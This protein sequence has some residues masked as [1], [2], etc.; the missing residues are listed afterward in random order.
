[1]MVP[2]R[3]NSNMNGMFQVGV[4]RKEVTLGALNEEGQ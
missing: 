3:M 2:E 4:E 1:M